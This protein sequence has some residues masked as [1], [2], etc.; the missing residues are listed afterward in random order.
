MFVRTVFI[1][2]AGFASMAPV[3]SGAVPPPPIATRHGPAALCSPR[4]AIALAGAE[5]AE[6]YQ[7]DF[8][9]VSGSG[10]QLG[11][12]SDLSGLEGQR[13]RILVPGLGAGERQ[14][15]REYPGNSYRGWIYAFPLTGG[16]TLR[17]ASD[18]FT[19]T[20]RDRLLLRRVL[21]GTAR[22]SL[23]GRGG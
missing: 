17:I 6:Q 1:L 11:I 5:R 21:V 9:V 19:G 18:Q 14:R 13:A 23:C 3:S 10:F 2:V 7:H 20:D 12:R 4:F 22:D 8:W 16:A 15:V